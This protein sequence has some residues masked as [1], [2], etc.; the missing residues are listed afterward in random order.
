[1]MDANKSPVI[2][3]S[4]S[5]ST[6]SEGHQTWRLWAATAALSLVVSAYVL[7]LSW[8]NQANVDA[9]PMERA[10]DIAA[11]DFAAI[12]VSDPALGDIAVRDSAYD[13][14]TN[15]S[16]LRIRS[17]NT[18]MAILNQAYLLAAACG[19]TSMQEQAQHDLETLEKRGEELKLRLLKELDPGGAIY[20]RVRRLLARNARSGDRLLSLKIKAGYLTN[21]YKDS[22]VALPAVFSAAEQNASALQAIKIAALSEPV[23][24]HQQSEQTCLSESTFFQAASPESKP[25][26]SAILLEATY[27][28]KKTGKTSSRS[29]C[30]IIGSLESRLNE[31]E[32]TVRSHARQASVLALHF[33]QGRPPELNSL[34]RLFALGKTKFSTNGKWLQSVGGRVPGSGKL[35]PPITPALNDMNAVDALSITFYHWLRQLDKPASMSQLQNLIGAQWPLPDTVK[36]KGTDAETISMVEANNPANSCLVTDSDARA[37][38]YIHQNGVNEEGQLGL[39]RCFAMMQ[40]QAAF[41]P[42][43]LPLVINQDGMACL[44][45]R[46]N[47][48]RQLAID[49]L[50]KIYESNLAAQDTL[51]TSKLIESSASKSL[52]SAQDRVLLAQADL[53]TLKDRLHKELTD[54]ERKILQEEISAR[55][56]NIA[57]EARE[58]KRLTITIALARTARGNAIAAAAQS[59]DLSSRLFQVARSGIYRLDLGGQNA[60]LLG[61]HFIFSPCTEA[62]QDATIIDA[63]NQLAEMKEPVRDSNVGKN[64]WLS[65]KITVFAKV[66]DVINAPE[67][68][69]FAEGQSLS[70]L[71]AEVP[72]VRAADP[73]TIIL[74]SRMLYGKAKAQPVSLPDS[75]FNG[76]PVTERQ[77][78]Y[79][80]PRAL[81]IAETSQLSI[82]VSWSS[83]ARDLVAYREQD[84]QFYLGEP[85]QSLASGWCK[86][87][88]RAEFDI[89]DSDGCP[90][91]AGEWQLRRPLV[92]ID[93]Q[94]QQALKGTTLANPQTGQRLPQVP[95]AGPSLM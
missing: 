35:A 47:F 14:R 89:A 81:T 31:T 73:Q 72:P 70:D 49:L 48:D 15:K 78:V 43:A 95:P 11:H 51:A 17:F 41:P 24:L 5:T 86:K 82:P 16:N 65:K 64:V 2:S 53:M 79:Y 63:A 59:F 33:P 12:V 21:K 6:S 38:A 27:S 66:K 85:V 93:S 3:T 20:E 45:G 56:E 50:K 13:I 34:A 44:P 61:K 25:L 67:T 62:L 22:G 7:L 4:K 74:D 90:G 69:I 80:C 19:L 29:L 26:P 57:L 91:L 1:M 71:L 76:L 54:Q 32:K 18:A 42:Q 40:N 77:L 87:A 52:H 55:E 30:F 46:N 28:N 92:L 94:L 83:V 75:P 9:D 10:A 23:Y 36:S 68:K 37:Y 84:R 58:Q 88:P 8:L 39:S 60:F